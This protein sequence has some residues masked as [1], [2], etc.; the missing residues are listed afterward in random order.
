MKR[1]AAAAR[2]GFGPIAA[3]ALLALPVLLLAVGCVVPSPDSIS[4]APTAAVPIVVSLT[5]DGQTSELSTTATSVGGL[6]DEAGISLAPTDEVTPPVSTALTSLSPRQVTIVRVSEQVESVIED[7]PFARQIVRSAEM[8]PN[9]P[10]KVLQTGQP[11]QQEVTYRIVSRDG[12]EAERW[13]TT[14]NVLKAARNEVVLIGVGA[15]AASATF[16]GLLAYI[17]DG[18]PVIL[19]G[20]TDRARQLEIEGR[21]DGRV[22]QLSPDGRWLLYTVAAGDEEAAFGNSLWFIEAAGGSAP[23]PLGIDNVLWAAWDPSQVQP[24][25]LAYTTARSTALPPGWE[26]NNDLWLLEFPADET[27][28]SSPVRLIETYPATY[29]W[30]GGTFSWSS[31]GDRLAYAFADEIGLVAMPAPGS[32]DAGATALLGAD[33]TSFQPLVA[34]TPYDTRSDWAWVPGLSWSPDGTLLLYGMHAPADPLQADPFDLRYL[35][36]DE[37]G[38][39]LREAVGAWAF[40]LWSP[41]DAVGGSR[42]ALLQ[43]TD[44]ADSLDSSYTLWLADADGSNA[45]R[46]FPPEGEVSLFPPDQQ[47]MA[48]GPDGA[49]MAFIFDDTL[50]ILSLLDGELYRAAGD[51]TVDSRPTWAPYGAVLATP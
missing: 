6:L 12:Q 22:F 2:P 34:F 23:Q 39:L 11:G 25:R 14:T 37:R 45:E 49:R 40:A 30:W 4:V 16:E 7:I 21:L 8:S 47:F 24:P 41:A 35:G 48:W 18:R 15:T 46:L 13:R 29:G 51:D 36:P 43:A 3:L 20:S 9:E 42:L 10:P 50:H 5:I 17:D 33:R 1:R 32:L 31:A 28:I 38:G 19:D 27:L 44:P 26:A